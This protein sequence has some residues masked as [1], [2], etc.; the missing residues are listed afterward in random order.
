MAL[1]GRSGA[2]RARRARVGATRPDR[3]AANAAREVEFL[4]RHYDDAARSF[5]AAARRARTQKPQAGAPDA[6]ALLKRG[7]AL[8]AGGRR[9]GGLRT[10]RAADD[11]AMQDMQGPPADGIDAT[12]TSS[13]SYYALAQLGDAEREAGALRA[14]ADDYAAARRLEP[15]LE[16]GSAGVPA[17]PDFR[18]AH[19]WLNSAITEVGLGHPNAA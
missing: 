1:G 6:E 12:T 16:S 18:V 17:D 7:A 14:A 11:R 3:A 19:L 9:D 2:C 8:V 4:R 5:D 10:L 13:W 15:Q